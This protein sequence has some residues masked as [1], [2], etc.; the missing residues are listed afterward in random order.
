MFE[1]IFRPDTLFMKYSIPLI[2]ACFLFVS[3]E[4]EFSLENARF[5]SKYRLTAFYSETPVDFI[6]S[7][8]MV[9]LETDLWAY[10]YDYLKDDVYAFTENDTSVLVYQNTN[11]MPGNSEP[12]LYKQYVLSNEEDGTYFDF[13]GP[14]YEPLHYRLIQKTNDY[15]IISVD[16]REGVTVYS[17]FDKI[18]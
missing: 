13:L 5:V 6:E 15:F 9:N 10:V 3:C 17:R 16:W 18:K 7:D 11:V 2:L 14:K 12:V 1:I 4:K 8:S